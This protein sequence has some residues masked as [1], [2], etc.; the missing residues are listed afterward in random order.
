M[1]SLP[2]H[3]AEHRARI[4]IIGGTG[5]YKL[6]E[7]VVLSR[8]DIP[9]PFGPPSSP[10]TIARLTAPAGTSGDDGGTGA[11]GD[12]DG[13]PVVAFLSRHGR[14]HSVAPQQI[15]YRANLWA[16]KSLGVEAVISSAAVGG[17]VSSHGT[18]TFAV[19]DQV[20]DKTWGRADT[21]YD[22][23][24]PTGVQHLPAAEPY[25]AP[26][27]AAL[28][29]ALEHR[30]E[31]FAGAGTVAVINGPRFSTKAESAALVKSGAQLISMTQ[32]PEPMLAAELNMH[33]AALAFITDA[34]TGHDGSE[35]VTAELV[36]GRL[37][38]AQ[39]RILAVLSDAVRTVSAGLGGAEPADDG[40]TWRM[41]PMPPGAVATVMG[42]AGPV[43]P[44]PLL[45]GT[46]R[47]AP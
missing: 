11:D 24:L 16:L 2:E 19:P 32:Y 15:N 10:V 39:P 17:L 44:G 34:D 26:L 28:I 21:F 12:R 25:S 37:A 7:A 23:S 9:T 20:L 27:R 8:L 14:G 42:A 6:P 4:A 1:S 29:A 46:G 30:S 47:T 33:F 5:L 38:A 45:P 41:V 3:Q 36:L 43:L 22:G 31:D 35:P 18:G 13:G 40:G